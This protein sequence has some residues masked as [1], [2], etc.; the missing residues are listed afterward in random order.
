MRHDL[1]GCLSGVDKN[2]GLPQHDF[3]HFSKVQG[4]MHQRWGCFWSFLGSD[5]GPWG[6]GCAAGLP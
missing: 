5:G 4:E 6:Q 3:N 2:L 1:P